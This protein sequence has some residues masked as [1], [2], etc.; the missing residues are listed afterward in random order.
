ML[1]LVQCSSKMIVHSKVP[2]EF[3]WFFDFFLLHFKA[4]RSFC[5]YHLV[6]LLFL[7]L[8]GLSFPTVPKCI[9]CAREFVIVLFWFS[10]TNIPNVICVC[11]YSGMR[12]C[13]VHIALCYS[14]V[15]CVISQALIFFISL[16][17]FWWKPVKKKNETMYLFIVLYTIRHFIVG[18]RWTKIHLTFIIVAHFNVLSMDA[19]FVFLLSTEINLSLGTL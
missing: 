2:V 5:I 10:R 18:L 3:K 9:L 8:Y 12:F 6:L 17:L 15:S 4:F 1:A 19:N 14:S 11:I 16:F 13:V 7:S